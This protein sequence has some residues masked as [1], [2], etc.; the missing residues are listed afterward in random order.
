MRLR[1]IIKNDFALKKKDCNLIG[2]FAPIAQL[3]R[4]LVL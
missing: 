4:A 1:G 2:S 3:V